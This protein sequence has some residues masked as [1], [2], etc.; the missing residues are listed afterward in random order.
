MIHEGVNDCDER[1]RDTAA[2]LA[3]GVRQQ[4]AYQRKNFFR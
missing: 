2:V 3:I 1:K 4:S